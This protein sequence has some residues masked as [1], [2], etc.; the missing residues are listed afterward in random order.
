[1]TDI[2]R[3]EVADEL[4]ALMVRAHDG[5]KKALPKLRELL[6]AAPTLARKFVDPARIT[7]RST[8]DCYASGNDLLP[9]E[10]IPR[11]L[12]QMRS[13]IAGE[14]PSPLERLLVERIVATWL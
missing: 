10:A 6:D 13:E 9:E 12:K 4:K 1:M 8:V 11:V 5:D 14:D 7:E 3:R 2:S